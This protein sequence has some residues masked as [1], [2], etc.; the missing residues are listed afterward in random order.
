MARQTGARTRIGFYAPIKPPD[1][2]IASGD[3]QMARMLMAALAR[4]G[5]DVFLATRHISYSKR[6]GAE[7]LAARRQGALAE[8]ERLL[9]GWRAEGGAPELWFCYHPY[10][11]SP[12]WI[13]PRIAAALGIPMVT[14]EPCKTGQGPN[15]EWLP[16][17]MEA[18]QGILAADMNIVMTESDRNYFAGFVPADRM[19]FMP[20]FIDTDL[21]VPGTAP[22]DAWPHGHGGVRLLAVGMMRPGAKMESY[23]ALS[24]ALRALGDR[25]W[26]LAIV[27]GGPGEAEVRAMFAFAGDRA[28]LLGE[29]PQGEVLA[30]MAQADLLA[31]PGSKEAYGMVYLEA[32]A[33]GTPAVAFA[34][35]GVPLVVR[36][37]ET[38]LLADPAAEN[39]YRDAL[40]AAIGNADLR[41]KLAQGARNFA[42]IERSGERAAATLCG[43]IADVLRKRGA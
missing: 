17:R 23:K 16:W 36:H 42:R 14:A 9:S 13:G 18:Q 22:A 8:A 15:G 40:A 41:R 5:H 3:R 32:A 35:M 7:H 4:G 31:W 33:M 25:D 19:T 12:D 1:H 39:G 26:R 28:V 27:G 38:G 11:K 30:L 24:S 37:A 20:P 43:V 10:D 34:N 29:R 6:P 21:L 2:P